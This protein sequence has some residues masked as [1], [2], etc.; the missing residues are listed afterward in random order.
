MQLGA[1]QSLGHLTYCTNIHAA[2]AWPDVIA[3]LRRHLP[4]IKADISPHRPL[5][6][7]LRLAAKA[8]EALTDP[9]T[10]AELQEFLS[11]GDYYVFTLNGFPYGNFHGQPVKEG[12]YKPDWADPL[13]LSY[14]NSLSDHLA[15]LLPDGMEGSISTVPGTFKP[16][17]VGKETLVDTIADNMIRHV[18]HLVKVQESSGKLINLALEPEPFC[19]IETIDETIGFFDRYLYSDSAAKRLATLAGLSPDAAAQALRRHLGVCYDVCH[20]A[21]EFED[22]RASLAALKTAGIKISKLQLSSAMRIP[23]VDGDTARLLGQMNEPVYMHQVVENRDGK[24]IRYADIPDALQQIDAARGSEWRTHFHVP[25]FLEEMQS[26]ATT[27][28]FLKD[29]LAIHKEQP[30]TE[31]LE[32][33]TYTWDVLPESYRNVGVSAAIARELAWVRDQLLA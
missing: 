24:L 12:A 25:I 13:R 2:E 28:Q 18:S 29:I 30:V 21:V 32:V 20:A 11:Q 27:Q 17:L 31:Q 19:M 16:W 8:A 7:G 33:E 10:F 26:V 5:G 23:R 1:D 6:V 14:T 22:P 4:E 3:G 15:K 9:A